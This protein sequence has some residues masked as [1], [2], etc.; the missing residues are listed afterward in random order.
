MSGD[1]PFKTLTPD[2][3]RRLHI[4]DGPVLG[5]QIVRWMRGRGRYVPCPHCR[6]LRHP[7]ATVCPHCQQPIG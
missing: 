7:E 2:D 5:V 4:G 1:D 3:M 6:E